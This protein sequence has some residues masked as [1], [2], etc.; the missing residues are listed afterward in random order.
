MHPGL[1]LE[2][3]I[4]VSGTAVVDLIRVPEN[5]RRR[6]LGS[7]LYAAWEGTLEDGARVEL[8]AVDADA[9]AFWRSLG[10]S[11]DDNALMTKT[12]C[13]RCEQRADIAA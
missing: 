13:R 8:F 7:R 11:G 5:L 12:V 1:V 10:F 4:T 3:W 6:G 9:S 2:T